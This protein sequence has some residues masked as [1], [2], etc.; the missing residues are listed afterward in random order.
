MHSPRRVATHHRVVLPS[1]GRMGLGLWGGS[2]SNSDAQNN[3]EKAWAGTKSRTLLHTTSDRSSSDTTCTWTCDT[4]PKF[5]EDVA[6]DG[7]ERHEH[8]FHESGEG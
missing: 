6:G 2:R 3:A 5:E 1:A 8:A 4:Q 7:V